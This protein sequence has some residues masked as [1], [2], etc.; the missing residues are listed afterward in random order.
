MSR[1]CNQS[2]HLECSEL[3]PSER[4]L[5]TTSAAICDICHLGIL[6][7]LVRDDVWSLHIPST[8]TLQN[9]Y[10]SVSNTQKYAPSDASPVVPNDGSRCSSR[11]RPVAGSARQILLSNCQYVPLLESQTSPLVIASPEAG[12]GKKTRGDVCVTTPVCKSYRTRYMEDV[13]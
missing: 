11:I 5:R 8:A 4:E 6:S 9:P 12:C 7:G 3:S 2:A 10:C 13:S 1:Y